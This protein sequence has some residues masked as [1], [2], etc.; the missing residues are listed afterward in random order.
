MVRITVAASASDLCSAAACRISAVS[1]NE[2]VNGLGDGDTSPD[3]QMSGPLTVNLR[4]ERSG[5][6]SDRVYT[7]T[8]ECSDTSGNSSTKTVTV[9]VPRNQG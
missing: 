6:G 5:N 8:V 4:A 9:T 3:W 1:S 7:V 2:P